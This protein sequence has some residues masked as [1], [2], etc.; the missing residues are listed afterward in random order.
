MKKLSY[1][2]IVDVIDKEIKDTLNKKNEFI[3][4][5]GYV[6]STMDRFAT[7]VATLTE[8]YRIFKEACNE[9]N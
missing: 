5:N 4:N 7:K 9:D 1:E 8:L 6:T 3:K 2:E